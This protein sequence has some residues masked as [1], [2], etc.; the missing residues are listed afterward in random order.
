MKRRCASRPVIGALAGFAF[1]ACESPAQP[2]RA[3]AAGGLLRVVRPVVSDADR[4]PPRT[5]DGEG[6]GGAGREALERLWEVALASGFEFSVSRGRPTRL[7]GLARASGFTVELATRGEPHALRGIVAWA[8]IARALGAPFVESSFERRLSL[9]D[10][11][12]AARHDARA[13]DLVRTHSSSFADGSVAAFITRAEPRTT[14]LPAT[15]SALRAA[16]GLAANAKLADGLGWAFAL[17]YLTSAP[18]RQRVLAHR[19]AH[20]GA[21]H[22]GLRPSVDGANAFPKR[23]SPEAENKSLAALRELDT[24]PSALEGPLRMLDA[25][26]MGALFEVGRFEERPLSSRD[27]FMFQERRLALLSLFEARVRG[28]EEAQSR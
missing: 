18:P 8:R 13:L 27:L 23:L 17:D 26:R 14:P 4:E 25:T 15:L 24:L 22:V 19:D 16:A 6:T 21:I 28:A 20:S 10:F 5:L 12:R 1:V 3:T 9:E 11:A 2:P 7:V